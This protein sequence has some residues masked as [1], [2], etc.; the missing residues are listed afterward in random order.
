MAIAV[1]PDLASATHPIQPLARTYSRG[2]VVEPHA[3]D[4]GQLLYAE[5]GVMWVNTPCAALLVP[6]HRAVWVP[7]QVPHGIR[8]VS[9][10]Q[11][12]N[13]YLRGELAERM[14]SALGVLE[15]SPLLRESIRRRVALGDAPD[16]TYRDA[17][18]GLLVV[19]LQQARTAPL[20]VPLPAAGDRR[21]LALCEQVL[22]D[23]SLTLG[24]EAHAQAVG[25]STRTLTRLFTAELGVGFVEWRRQ[26][27]VAYAAARLLEGATVGSVADELGF[28]VGSF[29][30]MFRRA[31]GVTPSGYVGR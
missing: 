2:H 21:L 22:R 30:E 31:V 20:R 4:W 7:P 12:C 11:L 28:S 13:I 3:H 19:E 10:L 27:Q 15:V 5:S 9:A 1:P 26:V 18:E 14:G 17:L 25:A 23:P 8:V 16:P 6:S 24:Y 29:S